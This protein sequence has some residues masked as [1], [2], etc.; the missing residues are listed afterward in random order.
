[1]PKD[2]DITMLETVRDAIAPLNSF[3]DALSGEKDLTLICPPSTMEDL[4]FSRGDD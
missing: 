3:T 1:M 2:T 4:D